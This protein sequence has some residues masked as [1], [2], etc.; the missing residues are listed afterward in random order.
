MGKILLFLCA[1]REG[2]SQQITPTAQEAM[3]LTLE[4][5]FED[6][7]PFVQLEHELADFETVKVTRLDRMIEGML[8]ES[9]ERTALLVVCHPEIAR[10]ALRIDNCLGGMLPC[11]TVVYEREDDDLVH[12]H[13][14]STTKAIRDLGCA[15]ADADG[16]V[17]D[18]I[19]LTGELIDDVWENIETHAP[20]NG[21]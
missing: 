5:P 3:H 14:F 7:V 21:A 9:V 2:M 16:A 13:H 15:P 10:D 12:V 20:A 18:L 1:Q 4:M 8:G 6:A 17:E 19:D 11:T